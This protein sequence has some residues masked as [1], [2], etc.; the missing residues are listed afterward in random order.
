MSVQRFREGYNE[1][2]GERVSS[3]DGL[4][5]QL[6]SIDCCS[7]SMVP[8]LDMSGPLMITGIPC[9]VNSIPSIAIEN[10][11]IIQCLA[12]FAQQAPEP[13]PCL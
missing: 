4:Y 11:C 13:E 9:K 5:G 12:E 7:H 3:A 2:V 6:H 10:D 1:V 8:H